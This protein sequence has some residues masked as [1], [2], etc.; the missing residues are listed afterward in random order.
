M[1]MIGRLSKEKGAKI[2]KGPWGARRITRDR[3]NN[4]PKYDTGIIYIECKDLASYIAP[5]GYLHMD[6]RYFKNRKVWI[7]KLIKEDLVHEF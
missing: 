1:K 4:A 5:K 3:M 7:L 2:I 6:G